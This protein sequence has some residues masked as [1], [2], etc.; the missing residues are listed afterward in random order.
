MALKWRTIV[1]LNNFTNLSYKT[2]LFMKGKDLDRSIYSLFRIGINHKNRRI[3][4][5]PR[6]RPKLGRTEPV[7]D[8]MVPVPILEF[9]ILWF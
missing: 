2:S 4:P 3:E 9:E 1:Q 7:S 6:T 5:G 8:P